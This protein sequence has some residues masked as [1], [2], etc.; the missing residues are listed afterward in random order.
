MTYRLIIR[1]EAELDIQDV[2]EW[3]EAQSLGLGS[4]FVRAVDTCLSS[5]GRN[6]LAYPIIY[7]QARRALI[8]RFPYGILYVFEQEIISVIAC[9][10][11]KRDPKS[12][13]DRL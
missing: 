10:H 4:E 8:R 7:K 12:W 5:I 3:Y 6:P 1:L 2:F 13:Q 9:F 11:A